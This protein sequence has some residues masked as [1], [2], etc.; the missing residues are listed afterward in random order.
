MKSVKAK[1]DHRRLRELILYIASRSE[2]DFAFGKV[3]INKLLFYID[4]L[5]YL[6]TGNS[7]TG[8]EY[9]ALQQGPAPRGMKPTLDALEKQKEIA[10]KRDPDDPFAPHKIFALTSPDLS[11]FSADDIDRVNRVIDQ[12]RNQSGTA[13]SNLSHKFVGWAFAQPRETIP[14]SMAL[15]G[16]REPSLS[17][18]KFGQGLVSR[19]QKYLADYAESSCM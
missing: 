2:G 14:Y 11:L 1:T 4:F 13:M 9:Q 12:F 10:I 5:A 8:E 18:R 17:E 16:S 15:I 3:K 7:I 19:A 6:N